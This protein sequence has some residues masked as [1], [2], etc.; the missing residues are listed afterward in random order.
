[1][2]WTKTPVDDTNGSGYYEKYHS[3]PLFA[4]LV[5]K[6]LSIFNL[7]SDP[8]KAGPEKKK[9]SHDDKYSKMNWTKTP[10]DDKNGSGYYEKY[11][12]APL[13]ALLVFKIF[14]VF[15]KGKGSNADDDNKYS[16][17]KW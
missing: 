14:S 3:A 11:H 7:R 4:L 17:M 9:E 1:M 16:K 12:S 10:V 13:F 6:I 15:S 2:N 8:D 5:F